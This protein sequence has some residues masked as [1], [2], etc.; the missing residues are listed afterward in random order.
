MKTT[1]LS[2]CLLLLAGCLFQAMAAMPESQKIDSLL[3]EVWKKQNLQPNAAA[4]DDVLVRRLYLDIVGRIPTVEEAQQF[5]SS[6]DP[7]KRTKLIDQLLASDGYTSHMFNYMADLL[8]LTDN[9]RGRAT[10]DAYAEFVKKQLKANTPYDVLVRELMTTEGGA[11]DSGAI[12][13]YMRDENKLD[14]LAYTVQVFLG[15]SIVCAQCHN[16]PFDKMTQ[17]EYYGMAAYTNGMDTRV[18][19]GM[20]KGGGMKRPSKE[21]VAAMSKQERRAMRQK[22]TNGVNRKDVAMVREALKDVLQPLRYMQVAWSDNKLPMLPADYAY[23]DAK[24]GDRIQ[25]KVMFGHDAVAAPG[26]SNLEA[27]AQWMTSP[28]N[29]RFSTV[30]ANRMWKKVFGIGLIE[31]VD[32]MTDSTVP[33]NGPLMDYLTQLM[34]EKKYS[35]KSFLRVLYNTQTYQRMANP[36]EVELGGTYYFTGPILRRMSAEQVWDSM[37]TLAKGNVDNQI[38][39]DS[40]KLHEYLADIKMIKDTIETREMDEIVELAKA[41]TEQREAGQ[42]KL[43]ALKAEMAEQKESGSDPKGLTRQAQRLRREASS[44]MLEGLVGEER[45]QGLKLGY[46]PDRLN[47]VMRPDRNSMMGMSMSRSERQEAI[48]AGT[49]LNLSVRAS[50]LPSPTKPGHFLRTFGQSDR[51]VIENATD[52]ATVPQALALLNSPASEIL[53]HP[54]SDLGKQIEKAA[55]PQARVELLY[56]AYLSRLPTADERM[57][58]QQVLRDRGDS[59]LEDI[60]HALLASSQFLYIQ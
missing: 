35:I 26:E 8:R 17:L 48:K 31:P 28:D 53:N 52:D 22:M 45:A 19:Y 43:A 24:P 2:L 37:V 41:N 39:T 10:A 56:Q 12:G 32:E 54:D 6:R 23:D 55:T 50:E 33:S 9:V 14:H 30:I 11:W 4:P 29:P 44:A 57:I 46:R 40:S 36:T 42:E 47:N 13:F 7:H 21:E 59:A 15:T 38:S 25:P 51:E 27:F 1:S 34:V 16:H 49:L 3:A 58:L 5:V 18:G 20:L 60:S